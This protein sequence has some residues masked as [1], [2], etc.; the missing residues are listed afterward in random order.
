MTDIGRN[1]RMTPKKEDALVA[2]ACTTSTAE[3]AARIRVTERTLRRWMESEV[4]MTAY[5]EQARKNSAK[6]HSAL[7]DG[8]LEAVKVLRGALTAESA[9]VRI[10]AASRLLE[11][12]LKVRDDDVE[13]RLADL[14]RNL[15]KHEQEAEA[16]S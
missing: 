6:A 7:M 11:I 9:T 12:G 1:D 3:A 16:K 10:R 8:Q 5:R 15:L 13:E 2:L 4:F 14:E